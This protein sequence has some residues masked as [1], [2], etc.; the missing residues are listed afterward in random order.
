MK[1]KLKILIQI[2]EFGERIQ[3]QSFRTPAVHQEISL[4]QEF[5]R[6]RYYR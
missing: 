2:Q 1:K 6:V 5:M 4:V 3:R